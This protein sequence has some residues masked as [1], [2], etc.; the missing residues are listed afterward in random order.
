[1]PVSPLK[2]DWSG[3]GADLPLALFEGVQQAILG[4]MGAVGAAPR[5]GR[6]VLVA[7][8]LHAVAAA[9]PGGHAR[10]ARAVLLDLEARG[11][12]ERVA[13][14]RGDAARVRFR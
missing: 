5:R 10:V 13:G 8:V 11:V 12:L 3:H 9:V 6:G 7:D 4:A 1:M 2:P 14:L